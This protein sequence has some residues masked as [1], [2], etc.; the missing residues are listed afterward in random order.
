[1]YRQPLNRLLLTSIHSS[2]IGRSV[3]ILMARE[4]A[5]VTIVYL[6]SE[7][8]D[9]ETTKTSVEK[10]KRHCLLVKGDLRDRNSCRHAVDE[11]VKKFASG[12]IIRRL[13]L[14]L[15]AL[16]IWDDQYTCQ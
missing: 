2:G 13:W 1:M 12:T 9:A 8:P 5:D 11:H 14:T 6:P 3:A 4:G 15:H 10:W 16:Q 7:Q